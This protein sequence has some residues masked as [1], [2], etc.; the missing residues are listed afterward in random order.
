MLFV[1]FKQKSAYE[2]SECD[3][4][5][6][7]CSSDLMLNA[8]DLRSIQQVI[9]DNY[10]LITYEDIDKLQISKRDPKFDSFML[11]IKE[12]IDN[13]KSDKPDKAA[14]K[15]CDIPVQEFKSIASDCGYDEITTIPLRRKLHED[16]FIR[17]SDGRYTITVR[18]NNTAIRVVSFDIDVVTKYTKKDESKSVAG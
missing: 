7:V 12:Y 1:F 16:K 18:K 4:S 15:Y 8:I 11:S 17:N 6:D 5:P 3:C 10:H 14:Y 9:E 13:S 2:I